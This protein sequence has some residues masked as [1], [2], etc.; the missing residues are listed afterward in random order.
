MISTERRAPGEDG[1]V[2][3]RRAEL[4]SATTR[5]GDAAFDGFFQQHLAGDPAASSRLQA[6]VRQVVQQVPLPDTR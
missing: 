3:R 2:G 6:D 4:A 1:K 5:R